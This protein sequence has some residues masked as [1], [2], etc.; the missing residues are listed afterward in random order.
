MAIQKEVWQGDIID[1]LYKDNAFAKVCF[2][3]DSYVLAGSVVHTAVAGAP[4]AVK[5][6]LTVFPQAATER[7]DTDQPYQI[8]AYYALPRRVANLDKY[9]LSYDKRESVVGEDM[10]NLIQQCMQGLLFRWAPAHAN[11]VVTDGVT[12][13]DDLIDDTATGVRKMFTKTAFKAV[14]KK[15]D[16]QNFAGFKKVALLTA[17]HYHQ[18]FESLSDAEKTNFGKVAD[19]ANGVIGMYMGI[20]IM[21]RSTVLRYRYAGGI[22]TVVDEQL[23]GFAPTANDCSAS[24]FWVETAVE[25]ALGDVDVFDNPGQALYY[26]DIYS[27]MVRFGGKIRRVAGVFAV[28]EDL[29]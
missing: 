14:A 6:N 12:T 26:G 3:A 19:L 20:H 29:A 21:M 7:V 13:G 8:D 25:R 23:D 9:E 27:A 28:V 1:N 5:K 24:L 22:W 2:N 18:L 4:S 16:R 10:K 11:V 17:T 15:F